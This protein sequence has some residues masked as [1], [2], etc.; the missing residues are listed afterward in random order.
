MSTTMERMPRGIVALAAGACLVLTLAAASYGSDAAVGDG[1]G[2]APAVVQQHFESPG[3]AAQALV[4]A[5]A[6]NDETAMLAVLGADADIGSGDPVA[7]RNARERFVE[8]Y[9]EKH[10]LVASSD[11]STTL[12]IGADGW[13][14]PIPIGRDDQGWHFDTAAGED[15]IINRRVGRNELRAM[16]A[17][18]AYTDAQR[19]YYLRGVEG[20]P[21]RYAQ[22]FASTP[23]KRDGLYW[24]TEPG[25]VPSPLG[26]L[27]AA[28]HAQGYAVE[29]G[30]EPFHG[31]Y[32]EI[33]TAQGPHAPGGAYDYVAHGAMIGG[34]ALVAYPA[35][36]GLSGVM[37]F[38]V[39]HD[40]S[41]YE[42][43]LGPDTAEIAGAIKTFDPDETWKK[44]DESE[45][46]PE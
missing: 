37:T 7:D 35:E 18:L 5:L 44:V 9:E 34:F 1:D 3:A 16:Q 10:E 11:D 40:E 6:A 38:M 22:K 13:P 4:A 45:L 30:G 46:V 42:K 12:E 43:D 28:A 21:L 24:P 20:E 25:E 36:Y 41:V 26:E 2:A 39:S 15:E 8:L 33:L 29:G 17:C 32:F 14:F 31:Y 19:E 23:G 27:F